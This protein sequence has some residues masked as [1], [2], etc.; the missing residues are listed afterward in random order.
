MQ[1]GVSGQVGAMPDPATQFW[2][3]F[4]LN[5][6]VAIGTIGAVVMA[7]FSEPIR[8]W[9]F[10]P[11]LKIANEAPGSIVETVDNQGSGLTYVRVAIWN[12]GNRAAKNVRV[13]V[14]DLTLQT[15]RKA[16]TEFDSE[17]LEL[18]FALTDGGP[19]D[20]PRGTYRMADICCLNR[21]VTAKLRFL[22]LKTPNYFPAT[23]LCEGK[24]TVTL[25]ATAENCA[26]ETA[27]VTFEW[28]G[29]TEIRFL[30]A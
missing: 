4:L 9:F 23:D 30:A 29:K 7:V 27:V 17:V 3:N 19:V 8:I 2:M 25:K 12:D 14:T 26:T 13:L 11:K 15:A 16:D 6:A 20:I 28:D 18:G 10:R 24:Y 21:S 1:A 22:F 5:V